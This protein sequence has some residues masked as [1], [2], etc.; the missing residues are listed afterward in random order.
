VFQWLR[1]QASWEGRGEGKGKSGIAD[2]GTKDSWWGTA[3]R[4]NS[5]AFNIKG[6]PSSVLRICLQCRRP[7]FDPWAGKLSVEGNGD[8]LQYSCL[9]NSMERGA[10]WAT[11]HGV[12]KSWTGLSD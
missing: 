9:E 11:V 4:Y 5:V 10:W 12:L 7:R 1:L 3:K 8:A 6:F 2:Q